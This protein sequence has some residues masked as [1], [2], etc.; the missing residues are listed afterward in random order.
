[1]KTTNIGEFKDNL[2]KFIRFIEQGEVIEI[3]KGNIPIAKIIPYETSKSGNRTVLGC[4]MGS[5]K[6]LGDLTEPL[7]PE[8]TWDMHKS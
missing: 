8:D 7:I 4:G 1:M 2:G 5:V 3:R 6:I